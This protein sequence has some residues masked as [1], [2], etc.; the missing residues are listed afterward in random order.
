LSPDHR[1]DR[2]LLRLIDSDQHAIA[3][4]TALVP[5]EILTWTTDW[6]KLTQL[7]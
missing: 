7:L 2:Q 6:S 5:A 1:S 3:D 4:H